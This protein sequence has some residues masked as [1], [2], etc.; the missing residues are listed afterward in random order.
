MMYMTLCYVAS[1]Y[2][3]YEKTYFKL[4]H[5]KAEIE[6]WSTCENLNLYIYGDTHDSPV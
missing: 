3:L 1:G 2:I 6:R 5:G 4:L